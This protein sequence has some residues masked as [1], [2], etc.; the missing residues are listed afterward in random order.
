MDNGRYILEMSKSKLGK[1]SDNDTIFELSIYSYADRAKACYPKFEVKSRRVILS[2][3]AKAECVILS[4]VEGNEDANIWG[5]VVRELPLGAVLNTPNS[6][7][8]TYT[9]RAN[10]YKISESLIPHPDITP[11]GE[12]TGR[13]EDQCPFKVGDFVECL[14]LQDMTVELHLVVDMP[15]DSE[16]VK[17][18][19]DYHKS[20][21][22]GV[23]STLSEDFLI[24]HLA[25][26]WHDD[27]YAT[28]NGA[29]EELSYD[30]PV[31]VS[32][33]PARNAIPEE[34][35]RKMLSIK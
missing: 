19:F 23:D 6:A 18:L 2:N 25:K 8:A 35:K 16:Y 30:N 29:D 27:T 1:M 15:L 13:D 12:F 5:F 24:R 7:L 21:Y 31:V 28:I 33:L 34:L 26:D 17:R 3:L 32:M 9:Y 20:L 11:Y 14:N 10:G 4:I 22:L